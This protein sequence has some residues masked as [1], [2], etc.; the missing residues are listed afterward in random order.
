MKRFLAFLLLLGLVTPVAAEKPTPDE[1][2]AMRDTLRGFSEQKVASRFARLC[3]GGDYKRAFALLTPKAQK[4]LNFTRFS[5]KMKRFKFP[6]SHSSSSKIQEDGTS[7]VRVTESLKVKGS[8][9]HW[10]SAKKPSVIYHLQK[11]D[12]CWLIFKMQ[13]KKNLKVF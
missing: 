11:V 9:I 2:T 3:R 5:S 4:R 1:I 6:K 12:D 8:K 10:V 7:I 13:G